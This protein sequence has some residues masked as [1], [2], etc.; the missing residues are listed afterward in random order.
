[1]NLVVLD[2]K[3]HRVRVFS[4]KEKVADVTFNV[5]LTR[6]EVEDFRSNPKKFLGEVED[7]REVLPK[8]PEK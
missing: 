4:G 7:L 5:A 8:L 1:M 3:S 2:A 6:E